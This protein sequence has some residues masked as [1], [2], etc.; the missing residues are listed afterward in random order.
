MNRLSH[1]SLLSLLCLGA[2]L[3]RAESTVFEDDFSDTGS[4]WMHTPIADHK[5][6][7]I[8]LYDETGGYQMTPLDDSTY[9]VSLSPKQAEAGDVRIEAPVFLYTGVG[10][11]TAGVVCRHSD[12]GN[13]YAF[14]VSGGHGW[15]IIKVKD[16]QGETLST[17]GFEGMMPNI[18]DVRIG[19]RCQGDTLAMSIDGDTVGSVKDGEFSAGNSGLI[20][21]GEKTAGTSAV[22]D[23][24]KLSGL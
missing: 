13:F 11:G 21:L 6:K 1:I 23:S 14:M 16:G 2:G 24:F 18:A 4:G 19:A 5:A 9:G 8:S 20:V 22:F 3:S 17:G 10:K 7:G 15:A 12:N